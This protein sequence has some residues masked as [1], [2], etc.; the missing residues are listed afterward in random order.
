MGRGEE[1]IDIKRCRR[2]KLKKTVELLIMVTAA[3]YSV[4]I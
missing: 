1:R 4:I 2:T 3:Q